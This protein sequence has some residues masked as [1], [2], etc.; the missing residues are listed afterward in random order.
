MSLSHGGLIV[1]VASL[2]WVSPR[3]RAIPTQLGEYWLRTN[4]NERS[5]AEILAKSVLIVNDSRVRIDRTRLSHDRE[6]RSALIVWR[7]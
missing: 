6:A 2:T 5:D 3:L 1:E 7:G 4:K